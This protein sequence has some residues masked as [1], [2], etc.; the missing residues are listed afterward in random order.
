MIMDTGEGYLLGIE[1]YNELKAGDTVPLLR[2]NQ[3]DNVKYRYLY[4][5]EEM[6]WRCCSDEDI[7]AMVRFVAYATRKSFVRRRDDVSLMR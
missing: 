2:K 1:G 6:G 4:I 7:S 3:W 5:P